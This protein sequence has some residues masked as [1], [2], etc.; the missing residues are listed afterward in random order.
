MT[1]TWLNDLNIAASFVRS[2]HTGDH[3]LN[4]EL[5]VLADRIDGLIDEVGPL[6]LTPISRHRLIG[7]TDKS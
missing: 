5:Q 4:Y 1:K 7:E 3:E 2:I 6:G